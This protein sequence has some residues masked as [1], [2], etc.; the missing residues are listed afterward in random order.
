MLRGHPQVFL[1]DNKE[2]WYFATE[3]QERMPPRPAGT[4]RTLDEYLRAFAGA[5][6]GQRVGEASPQYLWSR[7]AAARI[8]EVAPQARIVAILREP[9]SFLHSLHLQFVESYI[10]VEPDF[11]KALSL[12]SE[13][14]QG[15]HVPRYTYW[16]R[17]LLYSDHVRYV[18]QLQ[19]Y[20]A[21]FSPQQVLVLI[22]EEFRDD[23][24]ATVR[25]LLRFLE[26]DDGHP[27]AQR[28]ANPTVRVRSG[29]AHEAVHALSVGRG[30]VSLAVKRALKAVT[31]RDVRRSM[32]RR[33]KRR[34]LFGEPRAADA[35]LVLELRGRFKVEV[36]ALSE[37]LG[38]DLVSFWGYD[39]LD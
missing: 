35:G 1:P 26:V 22:Y 13:R 28:E 4:P 8:A 15:R 34:L 17:T 14:R 5:R 16:P 3:L 20:R 6:P 36:E 9:V 32:L 25:R 21:A 38:R 12:E 2:L 39:H 30:P 27:I 33:A 7:T 29:R 23:N 31:P 19:R 18:E 24:E 11:A 10:E 37:Y